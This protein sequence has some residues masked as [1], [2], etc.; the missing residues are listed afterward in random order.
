MVHKC[1]CVRTRGCH[2][3]IKELLQAAVVAEDVLVKGA[4]GKGGQLAALLPAAG[5]L[6]A[7]ATDLEDDVVCPRP[8]NSHQRT[9]KMFLCCAVA[10]S[11][12]NDALR[13]GLTPQLPG[14]TPC[15]GSFCYN[16]QHWSTN[17]KLKSANQML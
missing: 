12:E 9:H 10:D 15:F 14:T 7:L 3:A 4:S 13:R 5:T 6:R 11:D 17:A 1:T 2:G 8:F 16:S